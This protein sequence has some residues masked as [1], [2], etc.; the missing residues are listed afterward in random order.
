M[1]RRVSSAAVL[2]VLFAALIVYASLFPL[3]GWRWPSGLAWLDYLS[4]PWPRYWT[5]FDLI[6]NLVG[7]V[8]LGALIVVAGIRQ[9]HARWLCA[10]AG[11]SLPALLSFSLETLQNA[12]PNRVPSNVDVALNT[13]GA[14]AGVCCA[15]VLERLGWIR[16][17]QEL[18]AYW[19]RPASAWALVLMV[20]W[21]L[22]LLFPLP[23]PLGTGQGLLHARDAL[24]SALQGSALADLWPAGS[25]KAQAAGP[26][27]VMGPDA[28]A[29]AH[30]FAITFFALLSICLVCFSVTHAGWR[31]LVLALLLLG[32][33]VAA[34]MAATAFNF[35]PEHAWAWST[36]VSTWALGSGLLAALCL[37]ASSYRTAAVL[38]LM[39]LAAQI[40][41]VNL[42][43]S[44]PYFA[45]SLQS[46]EQGRF[47]QFFG[48]SQ[49]VGWL[50]PFAA[51][52][53]GLSVALGKP[54]RSDEAEGGS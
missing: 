2:A 41:L 46:W 31:R 36:S 34:S 48:A 1:A 52:A 37:V 51:L 42:A 11:L 7:Y 12:L 14:F 38:A 29:A 4:L 28:L 32:V 33:G 17:W 39:T 23:A 43:P 6:S 16:R 47:I 40:T 26:V 44:D 45:L 24:V 18:R 49:W 54:G 19:W 53:Y 13:G 30:E 15:W 25:I 27:T 22:G 20:T 9:G 8:P 3:R 50:W 35:G 21:P 10:L 5:A